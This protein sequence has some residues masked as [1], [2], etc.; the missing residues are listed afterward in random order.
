MS[1]NKNNFDEKLNDNNYKRTVRK[2]NGASWKER[3]SL[4][5]MF[6]CLVM[7]VVCLSIHNNMVNIYR[8]LNCYQVHFW[9]ALKVVTVKNCERKMDVRL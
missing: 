8:S 6:L 7:G 3:F 4:R 9:E 1:D 2:W 5:L